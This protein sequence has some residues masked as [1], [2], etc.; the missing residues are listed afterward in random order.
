ML[1]WMLCSQQAQ[2]KLSLPLG[3]PPLLLQWCM[4]SKKT[5]ITSLMAEITQILGHKNRTLEVLKF[6]IEGAEPDVIAS[7]RHDN[8]LPRQISKVHIFPPGSSLISPSAPH[9]QSELALLI[10]HLAQLG[11][12]VVSTEDNIGA[13]LC[14]AC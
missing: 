10:L 3:E 11:Y 13:R 1:A 14:K 9:T 7:L 2:N 4:G 5:Q 6:D 8:L 12:A